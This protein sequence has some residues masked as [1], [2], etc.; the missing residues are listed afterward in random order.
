[1]SD[2]DPV[3]ADVILRTIGLGVTDLD[4]TVEFYIKVCGMQSLRVIDLPWLKEVIVGYA[5]QG[6]ERGSRL[7]LMHWID[8]SRKVE[9]YRD[10]PV[11]IVFQVKDTV[12]F[13]ERLRAAGCEIIREPGRSKVTNSTSIIG[14]A[15]DPD[16]YILEILQEA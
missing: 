11:K 12:R 3:L 4:R 16:G 2:N 8:G 14:M 13:I 15:K 7:V 5:A 6:F 1:M 10:L 9:E